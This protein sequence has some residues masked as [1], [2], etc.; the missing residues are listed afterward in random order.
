MALLGIHY[1]QFPEKWRAYDVREQKAAGESSP[2]DTGSLIFNGKYVE[3]WSGMSC[4]SPAY[5]IMKV[6]QMPKVKEKREAK[7]RGLVGVLGAAFRRPR[8]ESVTDASSAPAKDA[9]PQHREDFTSLI[10]EAVRKQK[11]DD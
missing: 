6:L 8:D 10:S 2:Y 5:E 3:G 1:G 9:N 11:R 7:E 4:V